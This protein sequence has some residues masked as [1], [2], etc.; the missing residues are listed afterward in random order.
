MKEEIASP[1]SAQNIK[2]RPDEYTNFQDNKEKILNLDIVNVIGKYT[3]L[4]LSG[5]NYKGLCPLHSE[6]T[7]SFTV[8][9]GKNI[10]H[11]FGCG[12]GG[13]IIDFIIEKKGLTFIEAINDLATDNNIVL[14]AREDTKEERKSELQKKSL[15]VVNKMAA[16]YYHDNLYKPENKEALKYVQS[17]WNDETIKLF[18]IGYAEDCWDGFIKYCTQNKIDTAIL[19]D[20]GLIAKNKKGGYFD[21]FKNRIIFPIHDKYGRPVAFTGRIPGKKFSSDFL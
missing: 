14:P 8:S 7:P 20:A 16:R 9:P 15:F 6:K 11:C 13:N 2:N 5:Q 4:K 19:L 17:R 1:L 18:Q 21:W 3:Q 12:K 10:W